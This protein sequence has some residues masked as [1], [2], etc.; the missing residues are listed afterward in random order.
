MAPGKL[1]VASSISVAFDDRGNEP[2]LALAAFEL[3]PKSCPERK[4]E[5]TVQRLATGDVCWDTGGNRY[6]IERKSLVTNDFE[7]SFWYGK[8]RLGRQ[9]SRMLTEAK[10]AI[11]VVEGMWVRS[12]MGY[13]MDPV[14]G[15]GIGGMLWAQ[16][17]GILWRIRMA[18]VHVYF[19]K[20]LRETA[21]AVG[22]AVAMTTGESKWLS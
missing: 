1:V 10:L 7:T 3:F 13:L 9:L 5:V 8:G 2:D 14:S 18:G 22:R 11:L 21:W 12:R 4:I 6:L 15:E 20:D 19:S 17:D 16:F